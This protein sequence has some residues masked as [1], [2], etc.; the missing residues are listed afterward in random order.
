MAQGVERALTR[1]GTLVCEA[2]TGTGKSLGYLVPAALS[3]R[4]VIVSRR[5]RSRC[6]RSSC[7]T[8]CRWPRRRAASRSAPS[9]SRAAR[10]TPAGRMVVQLGMRLFDPM[11]GEALERLRPWLRHDG[12]GRPRRARPRAARGRVG[13]GR[14]RA[15]ALPRR[16]LRVLVDVLRR[17]GARARAR[18][19]DRDRQP[20]ALLRRSRAAHRL[21]R[22]D[23]RPAGARR[24]GLR[25]GP[26]ARGRGRG[27]ARRAAL[28]A[29]RHAAAARLRAGLP[30]RQRHLAGAHAARAR[31]RGARALRAGCPQRAGARGCASPSCAISRRAR[32]PPCATRSAA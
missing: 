26:R 12:H 3:G 10:T 23:R 8:I 19:R 11:H 5:R 29:R 7:A 32:R 30:A 24:R 21:G 17:G 31:A 14:R 28:A 15:R 4:R 20:R 22:G 25:R 6:S 9:C 16:A 27:V 1:G 18:C 2:G 13:G